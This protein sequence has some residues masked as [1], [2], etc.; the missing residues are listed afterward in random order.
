MHKILQIAIANTFRRGGLA[1][2]IFLRVSVSQ[3]F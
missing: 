3:W 2:C 1:S